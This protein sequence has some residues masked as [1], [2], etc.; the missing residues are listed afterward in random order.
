MPGGCAVARGP[1][2]YHGYVLATGR[3]HDGAPPARAVAYP[4]I[5]GELAVGAG[6][7]IS[8]LTW[9]MRAEATAAR[10]SE[11]SP[12]PGADLTTRWMRTS[13]VHLQELAHTFPLHDDWS[14]LIGKRVLSWDPAYSA[15]PLGFFQ[16][17]PDLA[18]ITDLFERAEGVPLAALSWFGKRADVTLVYGNDHGRGQVAANAT[19]TGRGGSYSLILQ[20]P[21]DAPAGAGLT[22]SAILGRTLTG[23]MSVFVR[24]PGPSAPS[25]RDASDSR[26]RN[27]EAVLGTTWVPSERTSVIMEWA[28]SVQRDWVFFRASYAWDNLTLAALVRSEWGG[29]L[30]SGTICSLSVSHSFGRRLALGMDVSRTTGLPT[31]TT[32]TALQLWVKHSFTD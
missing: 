22:A 18:D 12:G 4:D 21:E 9:R 1:G 10:F 16:K 25:A 17:S 8:G 27:A 2:N 19:W 24:F 6:G 14:L 3:T 23:H 5:V 30:G 15:T 28:R 29:G 7:A 11:V 26:G 31:G 13:R 32:E 20:K